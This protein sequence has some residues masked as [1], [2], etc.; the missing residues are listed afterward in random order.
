MQYWVV[1]SCTIQGSSYTIQGSTYRPT[2]SRQGSTYRPLS[3]KIQGTTHT[4]QGTTYKVQGQC[5]CNTGSR[6]TLQNEAVPKPIHGST[7]ELQL[8]ISSRVQNCCCGS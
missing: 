2:Y 3:Y 5:L 1:P 8:S 7:C 6:P 4:R